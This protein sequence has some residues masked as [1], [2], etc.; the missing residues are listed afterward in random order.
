[1]AAQVPIS[2]FLDELEK[3]QLLSPAQ[4]KEIRNLPD[5]IGTDAKR[6]AAELM[7]RDW[8]S[9]FQVNQLFQGRSAS[10]RLGPYLLLKRIGKG[11]MGEVFKARHTLMDRLVALKV[12]RADR[13]DEPDYLSR[14]RR[15][16]QA[17]AK[18]T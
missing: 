16:M 11:G 14:F 5:D 7:R 3:H 1:M 12:I 4:L 2:A 13:L 15:E 10:L 8:L 17:T 18:L 9:P 6:L